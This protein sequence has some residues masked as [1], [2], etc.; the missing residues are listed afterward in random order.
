[1]RGFTPQEAEKIDRLATERFGI[2]SI[3]LMENAGR[4]VAEE[5]L[6]LRPA[7]VAVVLGKGKNAGDGLVAARTLHARGIPVRLA[8]VFDLKPAG[9][10]A[11][12]LGIVRALGLPLEPAPPEPQDVLVDAVFGIGLSRDL[13]GRAREVVE[14]MNDQ[15]GRG[16]PIVAVDVPSGLDARTGRPRG[17]AVRAEVTVTMGF[18]KIGFFAAGAKEYTG[19]VVIA[20][21]G[22][23][24]ALLRSGTSLS[25]DG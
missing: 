2:P 7:S 11:T 12:N 24:P 5:V 3:V 20:E 18:P 22:Y 1:M 9:D 19:R 13:E 10:V 17:A 16:I 21:I 15:R 23:P 25:K 8:T 14:W 6:R 4:A